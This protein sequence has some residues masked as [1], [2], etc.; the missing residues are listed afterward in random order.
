MAGQLTHYSILGISNTA[1]QEEIRAAFTQLM[2]TGAEKKDST[3]AL[4]HKRLVYAYRVLGNKNTRAAYDSQLQ[5]STNTGA[6][7]ND[8]LAVRL[9][10]SREELGLSESPQLLYGLLEITAVDLN[11]EANPPFNICIVIDRSTSMDGIRIERVKTAI[12]NLI[13]NL[14]PDDVVSIISFSDR[15]QIVHPSGRVANKASI[16]AKIRSIRT[17]GGTEI[18]QG[19][20]AGV[21]QI[22][23]ADLSQYNNQIVLLTD[24]HTYGDAE[25]CL[26][27]AEKIARQNIEITAFGIGNEWNDHFLDMLVAPSAGRSIYISHPEEIVDNLQQSIEGLGNIYAHNLCVQPQFTDSIQVRNI[28]KLMPFAQPVSYDNNQIRLGHLETRTPLMV[29]FELEVSPQGVDAELPISIEFS[30]DLPH[31][32]G[33]NHRQYKKHDLPVRLNAAQSAPPPEILKAVRL[34]NLYQMNEKAWKEAEAGQFDMATARM[35]HISTRLLEA[36]EEALSQ[37]AFAETQRLASMETVSIE[38]R[39]G[40]KYG[41]RA[42]MQQF[43]DEG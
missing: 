3:D 27:L 41:T 8:A 23:Q 7:D 2:S 42:L 35:Q 1:T 16:I 20:S 40:L 29:L 25:S 36:G 10:F 17:S 15:A 30:A 4:A 18:Y 38:G 21:Q 5:S 43:S 39:K 26:R 19:L 37:Q 22:K 32:N 9:V 24:G 11:E 6:I 14:A 12:A 33:K 28:F 31:K 34:F 13:K